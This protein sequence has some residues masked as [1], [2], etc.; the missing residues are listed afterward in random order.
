MKNI[1]RISCILLIVT[2]LAS[3]TQRRYSNLTVFK[4]HP[5]ADKVKEQTKEKSFVDYQV[6]ELRLKSRTE[7]MEAPAELKSTVVE[8]EQVPHRVFTP[9]K[10]NRDKS[11]LKEARE[12]LPMKRNLQ[13]A[14]K[15]VEEV[16]RLKG[17]NIDRVNEK[18]D[19]IAGL[20]YW[21][22]V[23]LLILLVL[24]LLRHLLGPLYGLFILIVLIALLGHIL[25]IW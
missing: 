18:D 16:K 12:V 5:G 6:E 19:E 15:M 8:M 21:I 20:I 24:T 13:T 23:V 10:E 4:W 14:K 17:D 11:R 7:S 22:L 3:C 25:G 1:A 2:F 9:L